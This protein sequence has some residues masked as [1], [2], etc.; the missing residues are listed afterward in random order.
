MT[1]SLALS[2]TVNP[3]LAYLA[4]L[5]IPSDDRARQM[6]LAIGAQESGFT[7]RR[8]IGGPA[9]S[10]WQ[11]EGGPMSGTA[12]VLTGAATRN[13]AARVCADLA[14]STDRA[15]VYA[16]LEQND[17]LACAFARLLLWGSP[18]ALPTDEQGGW[19]YYISRWHPGKPHRD[20]WVASWAA[21]KVALTSLP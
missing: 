3:T 12:E 20:R 15:T 5:G 21:A 11:F 10:W 13:V 18:K 7:A 8:Q 9:V 6:L 4:T 1:P 2:L 19:D 17:L 14:V 16:A